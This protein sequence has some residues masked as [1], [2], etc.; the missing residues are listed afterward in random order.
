MASGARAANVCMV[1][2]T[3]AV[4]NKIQMTHLDGDSCTV[5]I[6]DETADDLIRVGAARRAFRIGVTAGV[7][8]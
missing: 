4:T 7:I 1:L 8:R 5:V 3:A 2:A 6:D